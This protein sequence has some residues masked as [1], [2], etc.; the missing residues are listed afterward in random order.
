MGVRAKAQILAKIE[1]VEGSPASLSAS[2][3][4]T[5]FTPDF[6]D[7]TPFTD[8]RPAGPSLSRDLE[9]VGR[10]TRTITY[11]ADLRPSGSTG[12]V[13][14][15]GKLIQPCGFDE[16]AKHK[17]TL[18][19]VSGT[20]Q[21]FERLAIGS[22]DTTRYGVALAGVLDT[23]KLHV[24]W[25]AGAPP[26][27]GE[28]VLGLSSGATAD[29]SAIVAENVFYAPTSKALLQVSVGAGFIVAAAGDVLVVKRSGLVVGAVQIYEFTSGLTDFKA[30][31]QWG[32]IANG[33]VLHQVS[34]ESATVDAAVTQIH[35]PSLTQRINIDGR[36][37]D[38]WGARGTFTLSGENGT[39]LSLAMQF[40]GQRGTDGDIGLLTGGPVQSNVAIPKLQGAVVGLGVGGDFLRLRGRRLELAMNNQLGMI[41]DWNAPGGDV[42][43]SITDRDPILTVDVEW[44]GKA[45]FDLL[46][47]VNDSTPVRFGM[48]IGSGAG[49]R[50]VLGGNRMQIV[51]YAPGEVD[52]RFIATLTM[53]PRRIDEDGDDELL[54]SQL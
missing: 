25:I 26:A 10:S 37:F 33:D 41:G 49:G 54:L 48:L 15:F 3:A 18:T 52:G 35:T 20:F 36:Y 30:S 45:S 46:D 29:V 6:S 28:A 34:G 47:I 12:T 31:L 43:T 44:P 42:G 17:L 53:K 8:R 13:P 38:Q 40:L 19:S 9:P 50:L 4:V 14:P 24:A 11:T 51:G 23:D 27:A 21:P 5:V 16:I 1:S 7:D 32:S 39:H 2:D 22:T